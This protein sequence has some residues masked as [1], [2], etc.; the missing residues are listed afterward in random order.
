MTSIT[1]EK[2]GNTVRINISAKEFAQLIPDDANRALVERWIKLGRER[3]N[4]SEHL[5]EALAIRFSAQ[6]EEIESLC[7]QV[8]DLKDTLDRYISFFAKVAHAL[9]ISTTAKSQFDLES[10]HFDKINGNMMSHEQEQEQEQT[11]ALARI[12]H[13]IFKQLMEQLLPDVDQDF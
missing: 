3:E 6:K 5:E 8:A 9:T 10:T 12:K 1:R 11:Y 13:G 2:R 4:V 7:T